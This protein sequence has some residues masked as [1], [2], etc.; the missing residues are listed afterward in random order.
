MLTRAQDEQLKVEL[1]RLYR[2]QGRVLGNEEAADFGVPYLDWFENRH[3][4]AAG[5]ESVPL[6]PLVFHD[7]AFCA[8]YGDFWAEYGP[9]TDPTGPG[10]PPPWLTDL[11]WGYMLLVGVRDVA[12]WEAGRDRFAGTIHVDAWHAR[13]GDAEMIN[14]RYLTDDGQVEQ[15]EFSSGVAITCNFATEPRTVDGVTIPGHGYVIRD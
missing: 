4:R 12:K 5:G 11:L 3:K 1:L 15:T 10:A 6:W 9:G 7:A 8:R 2:D 14:H 13:V